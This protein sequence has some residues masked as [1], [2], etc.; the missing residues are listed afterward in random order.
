M[1]EPPR[2]T[3]VYPLAVRGY[4]DT[5]GNGV[6]AV[7]Y[8]AGFTARGK[9][10]WCYD[11]GGSEDI[12]CAFEDGARRQLSARATTGDASAIARAAGLRPT[13]SPA[14]LEPA[15]HRRSPPFFS[16]RRWFTRPTRLRLTKRRDRVEVDIEVQGR[17][18]ARVATYRSPVAG[19]THLPQVVVVEESG[20][21]ELGFVLHWPGRTYSQTATYHRLSM[22]TLASI[23]R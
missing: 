15:Y 18:P 23:A 7:A 2:A 17:R 20:A 11:D 6:S 4:P 12:V 10:G 14:R 9:L 3:P 1:A 16:Q 8:A 5:L 13:M 21:G 22:K 19:M